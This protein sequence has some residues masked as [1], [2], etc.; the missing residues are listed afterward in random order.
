M[1]T[2]RTDKKLLVKGLKTLLIAALLMFVGPSLSYII[3]GN[4]EK[5]SFLLLI[6]ISIIICL[7]GIYLAFIALKNI[8]DSLFK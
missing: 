2:K 6:I 1:E 4:Q 3:L 5:Q 8:T 7:A